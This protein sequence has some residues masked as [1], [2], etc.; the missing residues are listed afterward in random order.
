LLG[1]LVYKGCAK[2]YNDSQELGVVTVIDIEKVFDISYGCA[3]RIIAKKTE[4]KEMSGIK[5]YIYK[6]DRNNLQRCL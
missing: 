3:Q 4:N 2:F 1:T 5:Y 6:T